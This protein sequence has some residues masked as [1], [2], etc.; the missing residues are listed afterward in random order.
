MSAGQAV[1]ATAAIKP[2]DYLMGAYQESQTGAGDWYIIAG[3]KPKA[4]WSG[5]DTTEPIPTPV[6]TQKRRYR[7]KYESSEYLQR[8]T[9]MTTQFKE[10]MSLRELKLA[11]MEHSKKHGLTTWMYLPDSIDNQ[12]MV[13]VVENHSILLGSPDSTIRKALEQA[14]R[15]DDFDQRTERCLLHTF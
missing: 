8:V 13:N 6:P 2:T 7:S 10:G 1:A 5:I 12:L 15:F 4:D 11:V 14:E 9:P 3:R